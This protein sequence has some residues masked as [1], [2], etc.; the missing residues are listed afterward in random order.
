MDEKNNI[1][2]L[3]EMKSF[4]IPITR[5]GNC[6]PRGLKSCRRP[7]QA[8]ITTIQH[9][10]NPTIFWGRSYILHLGL[11]LPVFSLHKT[12]FGLK[13]IRK[14][15]FRQYFFTPKFFWPRNFFDR[16]FFL[17]KHFF[18]PKNFLPKIFFTKI[19]FT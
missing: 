9:N 11:T 7:Y 18:N 16:I 17:P 1:Y 5:C 19:F 14:K 2:I 6:D 10:F 15:I 3:Y 4:E 8:K 13:Y 12:N